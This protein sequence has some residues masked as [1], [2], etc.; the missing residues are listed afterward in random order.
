MF[1][2]ESSIISVRLPNDTI[3]RLDIIAHKTER[4]CNEIIQK[5]LSYSIENVEVLDHK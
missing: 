5:C 2:K 1:C 3:E 4:T